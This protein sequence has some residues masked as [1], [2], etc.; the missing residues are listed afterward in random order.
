MYR[1]C[2]SA[3]SHCESAIVLDI[4]RLI[5]NIDMVRGTPIPRWMRLLSICSFYAIDSGNG[6]MQLGYAVRFITHRSDIECLDI[7]EANCRWIRLS[8]AA[9][10]KISTA[11]KLRMLFYCWSWCAFALRENL[12]HAPHVSLRP[13]WFLSAV[14]ERLRSRCTA[15]HQR[16]GKNVIPEPEIRP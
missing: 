11:A 9:S 2:C 14:C 1:Q 15:G 12:C 6:V 16:R 8:T 5:G 7:R 4:M 13:V 3:E 10:E